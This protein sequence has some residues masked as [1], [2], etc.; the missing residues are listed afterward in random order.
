MRKL[1]HSQ[2][3]AVAGSNALSQPFLSLSLP[4]PFPFLLSL[5]AFPYL[6][7]SYPISL[8]LSL[9]FLFFMMS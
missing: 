4:Y 9:P 7:P 2:D 5:H 6:I 8:P 1:R 3:F